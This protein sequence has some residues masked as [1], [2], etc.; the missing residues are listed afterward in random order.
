M[1]TDLVFDPLAPE[2]RADPYPTY[3]RLRHD[4]PVFYAPA[5]DL[6]VVTR[7]DD[8]L[9]VLKDHTTFSSSIA[10]HS[11]PHEPLP[12]VRKRM[13]QGWPDM[14]IIVEADP[15]LHT[16]IRRPITRAF[17]PRRVVEMEPRVRTI[18]DELLDGFAG[19]GEGDIVS[20]FAWPLPLRVIGDL[21]GV[22]E[23]DLPWVHDR[24]REWLS[25][26]QA[27]GTLDEQLVQADGYVALQ[28]YFVDLVED[29]ARTPRD[30]LTSALVQAVRDD[31]DPI[32]VVELAGVPLDLVV[33]GHVTVT[34]AIGSAIVLLL[35]HP[36]VL[37]ELRAEPAAWPGA[38]E[39][40]LRLESPAQGLFRR[41]TRDIELGG[42]RLPAGARLMVHFGSASRDEAV[43]PES[44]R[45][46][47]TREDVGKRHL[48]FGKGIHVCI[49]AP[50]ARLELG[51]AL[52]RLF[53]R[54]DGLRRADDGPLVYD[55]IFFARG[56][57]TLRMC[58]DAP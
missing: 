56:L 50:L 43:F 23:E 42:V 4:R 26:Y 11:S 17:T 38:I 10:L 51:I 41:V 49:G 53:E 39:E 55:P 58:W 7:F 52:P 36:D 15:P 33:A 6:W 20:L 9:T 47:P 57:A 1:S 21:V 54:L 16:R 19:D 28:R 35:N 3:A 40:I 18:V 12:E 45:F 8:V 2:Q 44:D 25:T 30:D 24:S 14:P 32:G 13:E 5:Y 29:R 34:R 22:P 46:D 48:A 27:T 31:E 37:D